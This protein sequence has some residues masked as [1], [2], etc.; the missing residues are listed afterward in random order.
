MQQ[1]AMTFMQSVG[2][3]IALIGV[4]FVSD[5]INQTVYDVRQSGRLA[6]SAEAATGTGSWLTS[7]FGSF[8]LALFYIVLTAWALFVA[9]YVVRYRQK[10]AVTDSI[11]SE[12]TPRSV[13]SAVETHEVRADL[14]PTQ[15]RSPALRESVGVHN[16]GTAQA[17]TAPAPT[18]LP[19]ATVES[20]PVISGQPAN[21]PR[22][23]SES[24]SSAVIK[25]EVDTAKNGSQVIAALEEVAHQR[26]ILTSAD[27]VAYMLRHNNATDPHEAFV[28]VLDRAVATYPAEDGWV[29]LNVPRMQ[30]LLLK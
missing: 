13:F 27:A 20:S 25:P 19:T 3:M 24:L 30:T 12:F 16:T 8:G 14:F 26:R 5:I 17:R 18:N 11:V 1:S 23:E 9:Y 22:W 2:Y 6:S 28:A 21:A 4:L 7:A 15:Y 10:W 29:I